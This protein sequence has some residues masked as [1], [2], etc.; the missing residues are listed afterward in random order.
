MLVV[1][2]SVV[3][4]IATTLGATAGLGGGVIIKPILDIVG[5]HD[6]VNIGFLSSCAVFSMAIYSVFRQWKNGV[7]FEWKLISC[8][9]IGAIVGGNLGNHFFSSLLLIIDTNVIKIVQ[10]IILSCLLIL[11]IVVV[12][13]E[14][15]FYLKNILMYCVVGVFLGVISS[16]LGIGGGPINVAIFTFFFGIHIKCATIFSIVTILFSQASKLLTIALTIGFASYDYKLLL[17]I[18]PVAIAGGIVGS[19]LNKILKEDKIKLIFSFTVICIIFINLFIV[20]QNCI[21][22]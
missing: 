8:V 16:F 18:I 10:A 17:C 5:Y 1:I 6:V 19:Y 14:I 15:H 9:G 11:T 21:I 2:Y 12:K 13:K 3:I 4:F 7:D 20:V 22:M